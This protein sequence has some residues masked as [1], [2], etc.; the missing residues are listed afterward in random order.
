MVIRECVRRYGRFPN[1][2]VVDGGKEFQSVYFETLLAA[3]SCTKKTRPGAKPRF[4]SVCERIFGT[5]NTM[6]I[7]NL[8]GNTQ[9]MRH[10]RGV[11]KSV[12]PKNLA[13]WTLGSL[14]QNLCDWAY[15]FYDKKEHQALNESPRECFEYGL[16]KTGLRS[17]KI[18]PYDENFRIFTLP[19]T[20]KGTAK[21]VPN[22]GIKINNIYYWHNSFRSPEVEK[23]QVAVRYDPYDMG[24]AY[25][26]VKNQWVSCISQHYSSLVGHSEREIMMASEEVR[27]L[28]SSTNKQFVVTAS[29]LAE[30]LNQSEQQ[31]TVLLQRM[32][33]LEAKE[34]YNP[35]FVN[36]GF[37]QKL[38]NQVLELTIKQPEFPE[39]MTEEIHPYEE[40]W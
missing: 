29:S 17:H 36:Q 33:D 28:K 26:Y 27:K 21:V 9:I 15:E 14:Y 6:F 30:F 22:N 39:I 2:L 10:P 13:I 25:A 35:G 19:T 4:G 11:T 37:I 38:E 31:E 32:Q 16:V 7:H 12:N 8:Q 40:F 23:T 34:I 1:T 20:T 3:F 5:A 24:V 18:I